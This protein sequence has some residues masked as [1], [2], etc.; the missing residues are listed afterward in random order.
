ML[1]LDLQAF[2][3]LDGEAFKVL[4]KATDSNSPQ[5]RR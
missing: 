4:V 1:R 5:A 3:Q 2:R